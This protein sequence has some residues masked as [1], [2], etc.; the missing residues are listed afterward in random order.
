M[1][2]KDVLLKT[3]LSRNILSAWVQMGFIKPKIGGTRGY[4]AEF[5]DEDI[6]KIEMFRK[7]IKLGIIRKNAAPLLAERSKED[8]VKLLEL[9]R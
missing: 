8:I 4:P 6:W 3:G 9:L 2:P 5:N 7:L 1:K